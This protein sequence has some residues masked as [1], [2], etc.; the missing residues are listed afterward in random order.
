[1]TYCQKD[2]AFSGHLLQKQE[3]PVSLVFLKA[4]AVTAGGSLLFSETMKMRRMGPSLHVG[5]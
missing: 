4:E 3:N 1:M 2:P 5:I